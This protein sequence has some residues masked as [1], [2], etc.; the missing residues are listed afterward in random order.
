MLSPQWIDF[1]LTSRIGRLEFGPELTIFLS[2]K[3]VCSVFIS[4]MLDLFTITP[5]LRAEPEAMPPT[6]PIAEMQKLRLGGVEQWIFL[7]GADRTKPM[8]LFLQGGPGAPMAPQIRRFL[9]ELEL[10]FVVVHWEQRVAGKSHAASRD[11]TLTPTNC[12]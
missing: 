10:L 6:E 3:N 8:L 12:R 2:F 11:S 7:R 1:L 9:P 4:A 5:A